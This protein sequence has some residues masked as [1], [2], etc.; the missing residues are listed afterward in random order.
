[1][2]CEF[3]RRL[4]E[5][6]TD[7]TVLSAIPQKGTVGMVEDISAQMVAMG[8]Q[9]VTFEYSPGK[10]KTKSLENRIKDGG[11]CPCAVPTNF[12]GTKVRVLFVGSTLNGK[13]YR[14][15]TEVPDHLLV[16]QSPEQV[17]KLPE[18]GDCIF[19]DLNYAVWKVEPM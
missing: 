6:R 15:R 12:D 11:W 16:N 2:L 7:D 4:V 10:P 17:Q 1:M 9:I 14:V 18:F 8:V 3:I 5:R 13:M 19:K